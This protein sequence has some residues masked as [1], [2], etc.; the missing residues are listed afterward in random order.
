MRRKLTIGLGLWAAAFLVTACGDESPTGVGADL[1]G[2]GVRTYEVVFDASEF[3]VADTTFDRIG[4]LDDADFRMV[5]HA[6]DGELD[7]RTLFSL[8]RPLTATY[9]PAEG[10]TVTDTI[11]VVVGG[12]LTLVRDTIAS[13]RAAMEIEIVQV[14]EEWHRA[15]ATWAVRVDTAG[16]TE[17]WASPGGSPGAVLATATW[18]SGDT[19][20]IPFDSAAVA[21]WDDSLSARVGGLIRT[22]SP[23]QRL[24]LEGMSFQFNVVPVGADTVVQAGSIVESKI[25]STPDVAAPM[26]GTMR[27]GGL[28]AWR[29]AL[30]FQPVSEMRIPCGP[31]QPPGCTLPLGDVTVNL[32]ALLLEPM[33][34]G[35]RRVERPIR[36]EARAILEGPGIPL[37]RSPMSPSVGLSDSL[38]VALFDGTNP[39]PGTIR[40]PITTFIQFHLGEPTDD[41]P[42]QWLALTALGERTQFGFGAFGGLGSHRPPRLR[43]VVSVPDEVLMR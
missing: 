34:A 11:E 18:E 9:S 16:V 3:L 35:S 40:V 43:L 36:L 28:P 29:T 2:P 38:A 4:S 30:R 22:T 5:A 26:P 42:P 15:S 20:R 6:Y 39:E 19:L 1:L 17:A 37:A 41:P 33:A 10:Q 14:G 31:G 27:V 8:R 25:I 21:V 32:A 13:D 12:M 24:F 7:A 23:G